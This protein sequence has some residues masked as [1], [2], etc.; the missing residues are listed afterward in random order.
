MREEGVNSQPDAALL[1]DDL[2]PHLAVVVD[3]GKCENP[4]LLDAHEVSF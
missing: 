3:S 4:R 1:N 2:V